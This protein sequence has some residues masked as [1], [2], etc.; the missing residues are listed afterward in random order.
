MGRS[1]QRKQRKLPKRKKNDE[2]FDIR[3]LDDFF[4]PYV[5]AKDKDGI[6]LLFET[7]PD[8][9]TDATG[10]YENIVLDG[11]MESEEQTIEFMNFVYKLGNKQTNSFPYEYSKYEKK[12]KVYQW[13]SEHVPIDP[14][15]EDS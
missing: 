9:M 14:G 10:L 6:Q 8:I 12:W 2:L 5:K 4:I 3:L 11:N 15:G 7:Y 1:K 13:L